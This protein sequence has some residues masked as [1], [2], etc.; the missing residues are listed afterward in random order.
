MVR[1][2]PAPLARLGGR[3]ALTTR[4]ARRRRDPVDLASQAKPLESNDQV[5]RDVDLPPLQAVEGRAREGVVVVVPALP[6]GEDAHDP[7]VAAA[8]AGRERG[9]TERVADRVD[10]EG[11][12]V[13]QEDADPASPEQPGPATQPEGDDE[14]ER[15]PAPA[16]ALEEP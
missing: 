2:F 6:E 13:R 5:G 1:P 14:A 15:D 3:R 9:P 8:V 7:L 12:V 10:A 4:R 11:E 16:R